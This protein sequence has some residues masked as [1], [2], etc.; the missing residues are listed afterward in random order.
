[1][2]GDSGITQVGLLPGKGAGRRVGEAGWGLWDSRPRK[3][4]SALGRHPPPRAPPGLHFPAHP[5]PGV[6]GSQLWPLLTL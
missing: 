4:K 3:G 2:W 6:L 1:M 5:S